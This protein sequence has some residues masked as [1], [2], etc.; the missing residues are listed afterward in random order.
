MYMM[1]RKTK[2]VAYAEVT[3]PIGLMFMKLKIV[4]LYFRLSISRSLHLAWKILNYLFLN[5]SFIS[6]AHVAK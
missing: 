6:V 2:T 1:L 5:F 4:L 3:G